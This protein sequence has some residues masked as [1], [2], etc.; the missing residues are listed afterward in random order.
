MSAVAGY[1]YED[2]TQTL[3]FGS[4]DSIMCINV[5]IIEDDLIESTEN[6]TISLSVSADVNYT[7]IGPTEA[8]V[9]ILDFNGM[10]I[11]VTR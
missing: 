10:L 7:F 9:V 3:Y 1:D 8:T 4:Q 6:F 11:T 5:T 2:A